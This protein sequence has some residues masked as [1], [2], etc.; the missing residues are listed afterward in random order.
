MRKNHDALRIS[1]IRHAAHDT[2]PMGEA[3]ARNSQPGLSVFTTSSL[4]KYFAPS[5]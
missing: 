4:G 2:F 1:L 5:A 3:K